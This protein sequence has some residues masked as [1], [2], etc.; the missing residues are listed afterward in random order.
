MK[1]KQDWVL[2][3]LPQ[4]TIVSK[5][6]VQESPWGAIN[7]ADFLLYPRDGV[8]VL[9]QDLEILLSHFGTS[10]CHPLF[11]PDTYSNPSF[12]LFKQQVPNTVNFVLIALVCY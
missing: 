11:Y 4:T 7:N 9:G 12:F 10:W 6:R 3:L 2:R 5:L 1:Y 8:V